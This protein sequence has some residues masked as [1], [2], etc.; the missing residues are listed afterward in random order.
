M[1][2][3]VNLSIFGYT[4]VQIVYHT[5]VFINILGTI[6]YKSVQR[7]FNFTIVIKKKSTRSYMHPYSLKYV[8]FVRTC[9]VNRYYVNVYT[10][11]MLNRPRR[12][13]NIMKSLSN[14]SE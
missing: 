4:Y 13:H 3:L 9:K 7:F 10:Y 8:Q 14:L 2:V 12:P 11:F 6:Q 5:V 1:A